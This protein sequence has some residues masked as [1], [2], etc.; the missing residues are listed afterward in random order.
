[1]VKPWER[2]FVAAARLLA[3]CV[4]LT[5]FGVVAVL[6]VAALA[7]RQQPDIVFFLGNLVVQFFATL[8]VA[9]GGTG[10]GAS[11][12]IGS[13]L[14]TRELLP[15]K[16]A[17]PFVLAIRILSAFPAVVLGWFGA[18]LVL[19]AV[20]GRAAF[21]VFLGAAAVVIVAVIPRAYLI[22]SRSLGALPQS[23]RE[24][25]AAAGAGASRIAAHVT[26]PAVRRRLA[27]VYADAFSRAIGEAAAV[28]VV[29]LAAARAG[30]PVALFT[31][32]SAIMAHAPSVQLIDAGIA[33]S[34]LL[35]LVLAAASKTMAARRIGNLQW[36]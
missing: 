23:V 32:P 15:P 26:L 8:F 34:A 6:V 27:G 36:V 19:P 17:R 28:T 9:A 5:P 24:T 16:T 35:V 1:M 18:T 11:I 7:G 13:A 21:A 31:I 30:Y 4:I 10:I 20:S 33:Q 2:L 29:F 25:A 22:A 12:G 3:W 14:L